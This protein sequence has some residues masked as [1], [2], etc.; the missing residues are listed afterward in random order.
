MHVLLICDRDEDIF[1]DLID[2]MCFDNPITMGFGGGVHISARAHLARREV[3]VMFRE[4]FHRLPDIQASGEPDVLAGSFIHGVKH[5][6]ATFS[7]VAK[8]TASDHEVSAPPT[9]P[10]ISAK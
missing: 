10:R 7:P 9:I 8:I 4:L 1:E 3:T 5:L 6:P 2:L